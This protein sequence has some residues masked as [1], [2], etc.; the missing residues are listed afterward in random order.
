MYMYSHIGLMTNTPVDRVYYIMKQT[1]VCFFS[2]GQTSTVL[3]KNHDAH[4]LGEMS[5]V[6]WTN[7]GGGGHRD[8][9]VTTAD[10]FSC[11]KSS[12]YL[13]TRHCIDTSDRMTNRGILSG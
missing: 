4:V 13:D 7:E 5:P 3:N 12:H 1:K 2:G 8:L 6:T 11:S 10:G 9:F